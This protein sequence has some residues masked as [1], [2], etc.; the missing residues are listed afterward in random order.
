ALAA[1]L[2]VSEAELLQH[3]TGW[4]NAIPIPARIREELRRRLFRLG[5]AIGN[6]LNVRPCPGVA[7]SGWPSLLGEDYRKAVIEGIDASILG[8]RKHAEMSLAF[9][10]PSIG[11]DPNA[12]LA[13]AAW[14]LAC[15]GGMPA[16]SV[17][18]A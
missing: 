3:G 15:R 9:V 1:L 5:L 4:V 8:G 10:P 12:A 13:F 7:I 11:N 18:A 2:G 6:T 17:E 16:T 14:C